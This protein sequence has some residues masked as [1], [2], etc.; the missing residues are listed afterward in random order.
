[1]MELNYV[2]L[3]VVCSTYRNVSDLYGW[4]ASVFVLNGLPHA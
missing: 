3:H 2:L 4:L 1:M